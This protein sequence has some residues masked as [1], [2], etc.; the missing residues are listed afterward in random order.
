MAS[1]FQTVEREIISFKMRM[2]AFVAINCK[3]WN[4]YFHYFFIIMQT[5][6]NEPQK[7]K[8]LFSIG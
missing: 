6:R 2:G 5:K 8:A 7:E 1:K 4:K 3:T